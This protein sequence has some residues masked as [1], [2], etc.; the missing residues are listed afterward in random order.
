VS[1]C[2]LA[3]ALGA[4]GRAVVAAHPVT[5]FVPAGLEPYEFHT[6]SVGPEWRRQQDRY[7]W[8]DSRFA[9]SPG[10]DILPDT[11]F[12]ALAA[13]TSGLDHGRFYRT[14]DAAVDALALALG[15]LARGEVS[16]G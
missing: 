14:R 16:R 7:G 15:R 5:R 11:V 4:W 13:F 3:E 10:S 6:S 2:T 12:V 9:N 1:C 8:H